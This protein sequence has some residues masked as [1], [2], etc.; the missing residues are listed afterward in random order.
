MLITDGVHQIDGVKGAHSY[1]ITGAQP[2]LV[3]TGLPGQERRILAYF[4]KTGLDPS[5]LIG[6]IL[7]HFDLDHVGSV[8]TLAQRTQAPVYAHAADIPYILNKAPRPGLKRLL[9]FLTWPAY[10][11]LRPPQEIK[12][13]PTGM[14]YDW[15]ILHTPGHTPGH[16]VLYR[17]GIGIVGDLLV[18]GTLKLAPWFFTWDN[19]LL[20][21]SVAQFIERPLRWILPGHGP[22]TP[23]ANHWLDGMTKLIS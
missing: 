20:K 9:P 13:L 19:K 11:R 10:G 1:L 15:E 22:A 5:Q 12:P 17:N 2:F 4:N 18:G 14:F 6:I 7:T 21:G 3:D 8:E 23:A 16:I